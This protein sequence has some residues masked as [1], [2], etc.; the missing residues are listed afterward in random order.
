[1]L[2]IVLNYVVC[3]FSLCHADTCS[4]EEYQNVGYKPHPNHCNMFCQCA[5][6]TETT[7]RW[8][9]HT[10]SPGT[11]WDQNKLTCEYSFNI[12]CYEGK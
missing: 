5:P 7:Y 12:E 11:S 3:L 8:Y 4:Y 1:M 9:P 2:C 10:C 6:L